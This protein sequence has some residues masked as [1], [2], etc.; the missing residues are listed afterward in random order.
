MN[1]HILSDDLELVTDPNL[2]RLFPMP[3]PDIRQLA[4]PFMPQKPKVI[5]FQA[6]EMERQGLLARLK[7]K[8]FPVFDENG[9]INPQPRCTWRE[10]KLAR[11]I[12]RYVYFYKKP[13][14]DTRTYILSQLESVAKEHHVILPKPS[15][16]QTRKPKRRFDCEI[17]DHT[18]PSRSAEFK[19][20]YDG[21][22]IVAYMP[23]ENIAAERE[24]YERT[25]WDE[26]FT[27]EY[28]M[29]KN[30]AD[31]DETGKDKADIAELRGSFEMTLIERFYTLY[32]YTDSAEKE[33]CAEFIHRK[34]YNLS[35]AYAERKKRFHRKKDQIRW[36]YW[37]TITYD[38]KKFPNEQAF[39]KT[40]LTR[41]RNL[42][43]PRRN[44]W[45]VMGVFERGELNGRLHFHGFVYVPNGKDV[46]QLEHRSKYSEKE[47]RWH[48]YIANTDFEAKFGD[49]EFED[50]T[51]ATQKDI[52]AMVRYTEKMVRYMDK[53]GI[54]YYSR[55]IPT[56]FLVELET[57]DLLTMFSITCK[58]TIKRYVVSDLALKR[59]DTA[60]ER[61]T[62]LPSPD[63]PYDIGLLDSAA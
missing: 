54:V 51:E 18:Q 36:T 1:D 41:F 31:F 29:L 2:T 23:G 58:R 30:S 59:T 24:R 8:S 37:V 56:E 6:N 49:N 38:D 25:K 47:H 26:L 21:A 61:R 12:S 48:N 35:V 42:C 40:L 14:S 3:S 11:F 46:G 34:L 4:F 15:E 62:K 44:D 9:N 60:I 7:R 27:Q 5:S 57:T 13:A 33:T 16:M 17:V 22:N 45:L 10:S 53:G 32:G 52:N 28:A 55:H 43:D 50:I 19:A 20:Y 39:K 63:D